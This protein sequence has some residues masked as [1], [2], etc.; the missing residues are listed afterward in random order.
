MPFDGATMVCELLSPP[1]RGAALFRLAARLREAFMPEPRAIDDKT[2]AAV[3]DLLENAR[4]L[5]ALPE[6]WTTGMIE[7]PFGQRCAVG[8]LNRAARSTDDRA[9]FQQAHDELLRIALRRGFPC[10]E[11][12]NDGSAHA[13]VLSAFD[14]AIMAARRRGASFP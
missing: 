9:I 13:H 6:Q 10:V 8:A 1:T 2:R 12:M 4:T 3:I 7:T 11:M 14:E 5:I